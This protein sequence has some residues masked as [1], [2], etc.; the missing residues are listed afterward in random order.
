MFKTL[1]D[2]KLYKDAG[3]KAFVTSQWVAN[4]ACVSY[5]GKNSD[6]GIP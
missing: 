1:T 4:N 6:I 3:Y 2:A 5:F